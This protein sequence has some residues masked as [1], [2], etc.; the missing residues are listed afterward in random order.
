MKIDF[1]PNESSLSAVL[2]FLLFY[3]E[4]VLSHFLLCIVFIL[5]LPPLRHILPTLSEEQE[6]ELYRSRE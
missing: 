1:V 3:I 5:S 4:S 2:C 6:E